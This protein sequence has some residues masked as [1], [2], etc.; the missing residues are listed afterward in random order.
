LMHFTDAQLIF[1]SYGKIF[2]PETTTCFH[3]MHLSVFTLNQ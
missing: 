3:G 1:V 2:V